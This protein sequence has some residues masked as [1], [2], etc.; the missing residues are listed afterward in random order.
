MA[1]TH[2]GV[3]NPGL[4]TQRTGSLRPTVPPGPWAVCRVLRLI[5]TTRSG[6]AE[7]PERFFGV[8]RLCYRTTD[9]D[10]VC[11]RRRLHRPPLGAH[12]WR[13]HKA[14]LPHDPPRCFDHIRGFR[15]DHHS[16]RPPLLRALR[17]DPEEGHPP[18]GPKP[19]PLLR[20]LVAPVHEEQDSPSPQVRF[21]DRPP[22]SL[23]PSHEGVR[24]HRVDPIGEERIHDV[25]V[26]GLDVVHLQV[27]DDRK[28]P[29]LACGDDSLCSLQP[30]GK[31]QVVVQLD[32]CQMALRCPEDP[33]GPGQ[34]FLER[35]GEIE[36]QDYPAASFLGRGEH[37]FVEP[38]Q[39]PTPLSWRAGPPPFLWAAPTSS[40][41]VRIPF[42]S[43]Y[44]RTP[45]L[46]SLN[47]SNLWR[48][49]VP[50]CTASAPA[51]KNWTASSHFDT[52]PHPIIGTSNFSLSSYTHLSAMG[53]IAPPESPP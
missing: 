47:L 13:E 49:A 32:R 10:E 30:E 35:A 11:P 21:L 5:R 44:S 46:I 53:L 48:V 26:R 27:S 51:R 45:M 33:F 52:P 6:R 9:Y 50:I 28:A 39:D 42:L 15:R 16:V 24:Y 36:R 20:T 17:K 38:L 22:Q 40:L 1:S 41:R 23:L 19:I 31:E 34:A 2:R 4:S 37:P 3:S 29:C 12:S 25:Q 14:L 18:L 8:R 7:F 43:M